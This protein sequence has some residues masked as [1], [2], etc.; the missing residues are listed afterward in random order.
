MQYNQLF[1]KTSH[2]WMDK[3]EHDLCKSENFYEIR[4]RK[5]VLR[6]FSTKISRIQF[7]IKIFV[8]KNFSS[9]FQLSCH[10]SII[11][12]WHLIRE[13]MSSRLSTFQTLQTSS[14]QLI[15]FISSRVDG[16]WKEVPREWRWSQGIVLQKMVIASW[17]LKVCL[18][19]A[20]AISTA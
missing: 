19:I 1:F 10:K 9:K 14:R 16:F 13:K 3:K 7:K 18:P 17:P 5:K 6:F 15:R 4:Q 2:E 8:W 12:A 20:I 11:F